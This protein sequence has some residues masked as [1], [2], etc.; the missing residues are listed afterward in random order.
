M[1]NNNGDVMFNTDITIKVYELKEKLLTSDKY[2]IVKEK[3]K[4]MEENCSDLLI[5]YNY[6]FNEY[7]EALRFEKYGSD[8][9]A[10]Q[11]KLAEC[12]LELDSNKY[13]KEYKKAYKEM[14]DLLRDIQGIIF[15]GIIE[16]KDR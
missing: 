15:N 8:V 7:N 1:Y 9:N 11:K 16:N 10:I 6:L 13:V 3:E 14:N 12:K 4:Q 2:V 5:R